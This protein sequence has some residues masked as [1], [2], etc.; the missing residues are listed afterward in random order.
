MAGLRSIP[1]LPKPG[2]TSPAGAT[3]RP[4][5]PPAGSRPLPD[6]GRPAKA[7]RGPRL[8]GLGQK[9]V[10]GVGGPAQKPADFTG[11]Q[12]EWVFYWAS[13]RY[14]KDPRDPRQGPFLG[15]ELWLFQAP[16]NA[17]NPR[18]AGG[19]IS[20]FIYLTPGGGNVIVR[21]EG[22]FHHL[23]MGAAQQAR[24]LYLI[25]QAGHAIDRVVRVN[26]G[27]FMADVTGATAVRL[28]ADVLAG[29]T[30]V[31][32]LLSGTAAPPRYGDF[33]TGVGA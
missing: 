27:Q 30:P 32:Q 26:D 1:K 23:Q 2:P 33:V 12:P 8:L 11:S 21:I 10:T 5:P 16:E 25:A 7:P 13:A 28:L 4:S 9:R 19:S 6:L 20:D 18:E 24:D 3:P 15:G 29:R 22:F 17:A 14:H 31:G